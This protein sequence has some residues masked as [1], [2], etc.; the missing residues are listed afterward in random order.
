MK[1]P[2]TPV[3]LKNLRRYRRLTQ[4]EASE[5]IGISPRSCSDYEHG[6]RRVSLEILIRFAR[7]Y[8][9]SLDYLT[10][11]TLIRDVFPRF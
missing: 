1:T 9:V 6:R 7:L 5:A 3:L 10:G 2:V 11:A 4:A 8:D